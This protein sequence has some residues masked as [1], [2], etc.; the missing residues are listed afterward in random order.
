M[1]E[2]VLKPFLSDQ[3]NEALNPSIFTQLLDLRDP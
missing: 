3:L 1:R 2:V